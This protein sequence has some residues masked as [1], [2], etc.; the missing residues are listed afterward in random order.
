MLTTS[1]LPY[2]HDD[3]AHFYA[4]TLELGET[5][6][7]YD[8]NVLGTEGVLRHHP[9]YNINPVAERHHPLVVLH[10]TAREHVHAMVVAALKTSDC[11]HKDHVLVGRVF[12]LLSASHISI[13][14]I[15]E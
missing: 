13:D 10:A 8:A 12:N 2:T 14:F 1:Y 15:K 6:R 5:S 3:W 4:R 11:C 9:T 7:E